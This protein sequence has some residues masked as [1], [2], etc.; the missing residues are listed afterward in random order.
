[1]LLL[2]QLLYFGLLLLDKILQLL[3][4]V[5]PVVNSNTY[6]GG[7]TTNKQSLAHVLLQETRIHAHGLPSVLCLYLTPAAKHNR[8]VLPWRYLHLLTDL[9]IKEGAVSHFDQ[10]LPT[11]GWYINSPFEQAL[12]QLLVCQVQIEKFCRHRCLDVC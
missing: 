9:Q 10:A 1:M 7:T 5:C 8:A 2:L 11:A 12:L 3:G 4:R 6:A